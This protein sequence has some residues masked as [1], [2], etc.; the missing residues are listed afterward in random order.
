MDETQAPALQNIQEPALGGGGILRA[1]IAHH[2][3]EQQ[4]NRAAIAAAKSTEKYI[5]SNPNILG[6]SQDQADQFATQR[7]DESAI[8]YNQRLNSMIGNVM[9]GQKVQQAQQQIQQQAMMQRMMGIKLGAMS[10]AMGG[11]P[12]PDQAAAVA[13]QAQAAPA[14]S[15]VPAYLQPNQGPVQQPPAPPPQVVQQYAP[16]NAGQAAPTSA[17]PSGL[18]PQV[19]QGPPPVVK[20]T[21]PQV[22]A[23]LPQVLR[24]NWMDPE[25][26]NAQL[27]A[28]VDAENKRRTDLYNQQVEAKTPTQFLYYVRPEFNK[29]GQAVNDIYHPVSIKGAGT[30][31]Q[32]YEEGAQEIAVPHG[33]PVPGGLKVIQRGSLDLDKNPQPNVQPGE[34]G[35][36]LYDFNPSAE[37]HQ[38]EIKNAWSNAQGSALAYGDARL[39]ERAVQDYNA[40]GDPRWNQLQGNEK[41]AAAYQIIHGTNPLK[42]LEMAKGFNTQAVMA[43]IRGPNGSVGGRILQNEFDNAMKILADPQATPDVMLRAA[44]NITLLNQRANDINQYYARLVE[45]YPASV[46]FSRAAQRFGG[47]PSFLSPSDQLPDPRPA[48]TIA[49]KNGHIRVLVK[50][51]KGG[52]QQGYVPQENM[53]KALDNPSVIPAW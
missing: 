27:Q 30:L 10:D 18:Q 6:M 50:N 20:V 38:E 43:Q 52:L 33:A 9:V 39:L 51:D 3:D 46:A 4:A 47:V 24:Q 32:T 35:A 17:P 8:Q 36:N 7:A 49:P 45:K 29:D 53:D 14:P 34:G 22:R 44:R 21:D 11:Q 23:L 13:P 19:R 25:K 42:A 41:I 5:S 16:A 1:L 15:S 40:S 37:G 31:A 2:I 48:A 28:M 12:T 26:A